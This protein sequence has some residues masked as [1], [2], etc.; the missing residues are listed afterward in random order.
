MEAGAYEHLFLVSAVYV[1]KKKDMRRAELRY[2]I[3]E[4]E[5][6]SFW[7]KAQGIL[8]CEFKEPSSIGLLVQKVKEKGV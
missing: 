2:T 5:D 4:R 1:C 6:L 8:E 7:T 3:K